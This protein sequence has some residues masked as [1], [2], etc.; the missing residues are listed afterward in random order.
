MFVHPDKVLKAFYDRLKEIDVDIEVAL[1]NNVV[2]PAELPYLAVAVANRATEDRSLSGDME[3]TT[4]TMVITVVSAL[5][6][7]TSAAE[8]LAVQVKE[9]FPRLWTATIPGP[10]GGEVKVM[11]PPDIVAGYADEVNW[12]VPIRIRWM[13]K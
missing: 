13:A 3:H 8:D 12:R 11:A 7:F 9:L 2:T 5:N 1:P 6:A 4:G 10:G